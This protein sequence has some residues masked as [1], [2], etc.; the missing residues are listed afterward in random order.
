MVGIEVCREDPARN[1]VGD[2]TQF[3]AAI[4][5]DPSF[6]GPGVAQDES[7]VASRASQ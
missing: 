3:G 5:A 4:R 1:L 6:A 7:L 2:H